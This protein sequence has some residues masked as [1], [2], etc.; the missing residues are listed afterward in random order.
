MGPFELMDL[1]GIDVNFAAARSSTRHL[2]RLA[3]PAAPDPAVD[4]ASGRLGR[5]TGIGYYQLRR[6]GPEAGAGMNA[7]SGSSAQLRV[8]PGGRA[9]Q[10]AQVDRLVILSERF[11]PLAAALAH[12]AGAS[13]EVLHI[14]ADAEDLNEEELAARAR[15]GVVGIDLCFWDLEI[16]AWALDF[17]AHA[18][19][20]EAPILTCCHVATATEAAAQIGSDRV[21]GFAILPPIDDRRT[22][23]CARALQT[24]DRA[25]AAAAAFWQVLGFEPIWLA[26]AVGLVTPRIVAGLVNEAAFA[27]MEQAA[28]GADID[29]AMELG[30]R[31]PRGPLAWANLIGVDHVVAILDALKRTST[32]TVVISPLPFCGVSSRPAGRKISPGVSGRPLKT[33][34]GAHAWTK[35]KTALVLGGAGLVGLAVSRCLVEEGVATLLVAGLTEDEAKEAVHQLKLEAPP[36]AATTLVPIWGN[37]FVRSSLAHTPLAAL[38]QDP[39]SQ[40][41]LLADD[42]DELTTEGYQASHLVQLI[43]GTSDIAPGHRPHIVVD[44]INTATVLAYSGVYEAIARMM[45]ARASGEAVGVLDQVDTLLNSFATPRLVRHIQLLTQATLE[46]GTQVYLKIGTTG[47]GGMGINIPYTH[48]EEKPSRVLLG[49]SALAGAHSMLLF[50]FA[51]TPGAPLVKEIKP[52]AAITWKRIAHGPVRRRGQ[53]IPLFDCTLEDAVH[54]DRL[55]AGDSFS[56]AGHGHAIGGELESVFIDTGENGLFSVAEF[57][58]ITALGQMEAVTPEEIAA[59]AIREMQGKT[60]GRDI[61]A[62]LDGAVLGPSY[63]AGVLRSHALQEAKE[64]AARLEATSI[65]FEILGPPR[66]SKL[67]YEGELLRRA[68]GSLARLAAASVDEIVAGLETAVLSSH[69]V[70]RAAI[71]V[72]IPILMGDGQTLLA[73]DRPLRQ[74]RWEAESWTPSAD[75]IARWRRTE[76]IDLGAENALAWKTRAATILAKEAVGHDL[77]ITSSSLDRRFPRDGHAEFDIGALA[78]WVFIHEDGGGR[79]P[80]LG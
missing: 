63:R 56:L 54:L 41:Q 76:W 46:A 20:P 70:R 66:L 77:A 61:I 74:H 27:L 47:T 55:S 71:S 51:R 2:R 13:F 18:L 3:L 23:E 65:A 62:A 36:T 73:A 14:E 9:G 64:L 37:I 53:P 40:A 33:N 31:Y 38:R 12:R 78:A 8:M 7:K 69:D 34:R 10:V 67:L 28:T 6:R 21:T 59:L 43:L 19:E 17:L 48:G 58:A 26:D 49:K 39:T 45:V 32:A 15:H 24:S 75:T 44:C 4:G 50:L 29:R 35:G 52:G 25:A 5:K 11:S 68:F 57:S 22:I 42:L 80:G 1:I 16:K 30:T 72:G 60:T 79:V